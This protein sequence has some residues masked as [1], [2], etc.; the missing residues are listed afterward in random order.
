MR[1]LDVCRKLLALQS[2]HLLALPTQAGDVY[3]SEVLADPTPG[4]DG[5]HGIRKDVDDGQCG[6]KS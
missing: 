5:D 6:G 4:F 2:L 1:L 3:I